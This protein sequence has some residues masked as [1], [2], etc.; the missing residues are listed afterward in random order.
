MSDE[1]RVYLQCPA[2]SGIEEK[3]QTI[4]VEMRA[5]RDI[6]AN[7]AKHN[8]DELQR[9]EMEN[10]NAIEI[11]HARIAKHEEERTQERIGMIEALGSNRKATEAIRT[12]VHRM[13]VRFLALVLTIVGLPAVGLLVNAIIQHILVKPT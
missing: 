7:G 4:L 11:I 12:E 1:S 10:K 5:M 6:F 2:H 9:I 3:F 8:E 13:Q